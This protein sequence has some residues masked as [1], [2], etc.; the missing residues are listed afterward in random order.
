MPELLTVREAAQRLSS[1]RD[2]ILKMLHAGRFPRAFQTGA[3][4]P[5]CCWRIPLADIEALQEQKGSR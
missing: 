1:N 2:T 5:G 3:G 4:T